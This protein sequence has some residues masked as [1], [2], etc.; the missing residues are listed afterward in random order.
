MP[1]DPL[2]GVILVVDDRENVRD[3]L[4][5]QLQDFKHTVL[6]ASDGVEALH[7][8]RRRNGAVDLILSAVAMPHM[9]GTEL[10]GRI[11]GEFPG[12]P[13]ILMS[14]FA[15]PEMAGASQGETILPVLRTP[16]DAAHLGELVALTLQ[17]PMMPRADVAVPA[18]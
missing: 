10:A 15:V 6:E 14:A 9:N 7:L 18:L 5:R 3:A 17:H 8:V 2:T 11:G 4:R 16:F 1:R 12:V 13:V